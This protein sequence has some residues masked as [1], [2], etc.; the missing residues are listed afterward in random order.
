MTQETGSHEPDPYQE[1]LDRYWAFIR[2]RAWLLALGLT[3]LGDVVV[4][5]LTRNAVPV[6]AYSP[7]S[8]LIFLFTFRLSARYG[9]WLTGG[10]PPLKH[11]DGEPGEPPNDSLRPLKDEP[12]GLRA[13]IFGYGVLSFILAC[14]ASAA[15]WYAGL[16]G[17]WRPALLS[18]LLFGVM[19]ANTYW[20]WRLFGPTQVLRRLRKRQTSGQMVGT[21]VISSLS[22]IAVAN[23][24]TV[25]VCGLALALASGQVWWFIPFGLLSLV[26]GVVLWWRVGECVAALLPDGGA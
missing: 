23:C 12:M 15:L 6:L 10:T 3:V 18:W 25:A 14:A 8:F 19:A 22:W 11:V 17:D 1:R 9:P 16:R 26:T 21:G 4:I 24:I 2:S 7:L 13:R 20:L 5:A